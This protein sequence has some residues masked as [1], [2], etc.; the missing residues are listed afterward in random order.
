M[1][2]LFRNF[3]ALFLSV[4]VIMIL[5]S[6]VATVLAD[7]AVGSFIYGN[8]TDDQ[9]FY[10]RVVK[11][12]NG[13]L[14]ATMEKEFPINTNWVG[15]KSYNFYSS[16]NNGRTWSLVSELDPSSYSG[17]SRDKMGM[18]GL[19]VLPQAMGNY[20]AGTI[21]F[22]TCDWDWNAPYCLHIWRS[23]DNGSSWQFHANLAP[24]GTGKSAWEPEFAVSSDG[25][26][27]CYYS[28]ER[29]AGYDQCIALETSSDG[30][31][32]WSNYTIVAGQYDANFVRGVTQDAWRPGMPRVTKLSDGSYVMVYE[33][34]GL[35]RGGIISCRNSSDGINWGSQ[36]TLGTLVSSNGYSAYQ[37]PMIACIDDGSTYGRLF[38]RG[39]NDTCSPSQCLT[40]TDKGATWQFID[41][42]LTAVRKE[43]VA[44]SWSGT[45]LAD[46]NRLIELNN[47][48]N[49]SF[50]EVRCGTG[51]LYDGQLIV[52]GA[53]YRII[54][55]ASGFCLDDAG[56][57]MDWGNQLIQW[58]NNGLRTQFWQLENAVGS[59]FTFVCSFSNLAMDN[60][61]GSMTSGTRIQQWD[62]NYAIAEQWKL[63]PDGG[64]RF[65]IQN[66]CSGL[67]LDT[68]G[69]STA[70]AAFIVQNSLSSN[71]TQKWYI[72]RVYET[73]TLKS[74]NIPSCY[75]YH[76]SSNSVV[77]ANTSTSLPLTSSQWRIMPGLANAGDVSFESID[78]PGYYLR[79]YNGNVIISQNDGSEIFKSDAT[80]RV[81][82]A[83]DGAAGSSFETYAFN[84]VYMRHYNGNLMISQISTALD[85][86]DASFFMTYQ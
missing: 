78:R 9:C 66:Q 21:L 84:G 12:P 82:G 52:S 29:P 23:T 63:I 1:K 33:N 26:L 4:L 45:F 70:N 46:G 30:G 40:S 58:T 42:P 28:D 15:M 62:V 55:V 39:M 38:V 69:Q 20:P 77:I 18:P 37:T 34:I 41:A 60:P 8:T 71:N 43:S 86:Q 81:H 73:I 44:S 72:Q 75:V 13:N 48:Y 64:G 32:T 36:T 68:E 59:N 54:N 5:P 57:S 85:R 83:L 67:Y 16:A 51:I 22:A 14:L 10:E 65:K 53:D 50:N 17:M 76:N 35:G 49:G 79:H 25:R 19:F 47:H 61:M 2:N 56:G 11:L 6:N 80:W 7:D 24:R 3:L 31:I 74:N 27:V